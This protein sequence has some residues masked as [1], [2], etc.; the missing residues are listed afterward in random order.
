MS[1]LLHGQELQVIQEKHCGFF[2]RRHKSGSFGT[3]SLQLLGKTM[4]QV[5]FTP[6][7]YTDSGEN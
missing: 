1:K 6:L 7:K 4:F 2:V 3:N 5:S